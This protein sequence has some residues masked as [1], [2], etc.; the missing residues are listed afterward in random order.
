MRQAAIDVGVRMAIVAA[1][2]AAILLARWPAA[3]WR[4]RRLRRALEFGSAPKV[5]AGSPTVLLFSG[6][7]C[8]HCERQKAIL[9][10]VQLTLRN[11]WRV[12]EVHAASEAQLARQ[13]GVESV[14]ATVVLDGGGRA[15][16]VNY[17]LVTAAAL[18]R[19]LEPVLSPG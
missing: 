5:T 2:G 10:E 1:I 14:P 17:G 6:T 19:Q 16:A 8:G 7:L 11:G 9:S 13:F 18:R 15:R 12:R 3:V 4:A